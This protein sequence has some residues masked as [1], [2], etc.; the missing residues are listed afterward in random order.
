MK[1]DR[2]M[3]SDRLEAD[4][5]FKDYESVQVIVLLLSFNIGK[6]VTSEDISSCSM[7][8]SWSCRKTIF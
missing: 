7:T 6:V 1:E 5:N 3:T 8:P 4:D 2:F